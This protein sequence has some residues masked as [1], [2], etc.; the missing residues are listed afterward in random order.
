M[1]SNALRRFQKWIAKWLML[2]SALQPL[3]GAQEQPE[4]FYYLAVPSC[5]QKG[6]CLFVACIQLDHKGNPVQLSPKSGKSSTPFFSIWRSSYWDE[7]AP[8]GSMRTPADW[9]YAIETKAERAIARKP[10]FA[11]LPE[12]IRQFFFE[13]EKLRCISMQEIILQPL[14]RT[15]GFIGWQHVKHLDVLA[16]PAST[17]AED[18]SKAFLLSLREPKE[19]DPA[20][21]LNACFSLLHLKTQSIRYWPEYNVFLIE[22]HADFKDVVE[23]LFSPT[24]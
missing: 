24:Y 11:P 15:E 20:K 7:H 16:T 10:E 6:E 18:R 21:A 9:K 14:F 1:R 17:S 23:T 5:P 3:L 4:L 2:F 19:K 13:L 22:A 12:S 8:E